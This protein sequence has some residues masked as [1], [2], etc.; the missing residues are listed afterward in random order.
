[1]TQ[2][3]IQKGHL[4]DLKDLNKEEENFTDINNISNE[5]KKN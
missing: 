1:M 3:S 4:T 2:I 5:E